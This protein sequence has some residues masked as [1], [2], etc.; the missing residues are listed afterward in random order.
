[1]QVPSGMNDPRMIEFSVLNAATGGSETTAGLS[2]DLTGNP[3]LDLTLV[4][5]HV[6]TPQQTS[7]GSTPLQDDFRFLVGVS[8]DL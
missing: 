3:N 2:I 4:W 6:Q 1:M 8:V 7:A 5:D